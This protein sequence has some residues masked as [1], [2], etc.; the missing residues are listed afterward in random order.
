MNIREIIEKKSHSQALSPEEITWFVQSLNDDTLVDY[1]ITALLMAIFINGM[2]KEET[3]ALTKA[4]MA[5]GKCLNFNDPAVVDKHSTGGVGDKTS[6]VVAP[7]AAA[8]GVKVPMVAGKGLG[9]TGGTVDK[10]ESIPGFNAKVSLDDFAS[11]LKTN[12]LVLTGQT[13]EIA[14]ADKKLYAL[15]DVT[16]TINSIPL[17]TAS[18]MSKKLSEGVSGL[19][20][21][22]KYGSGAFRKTIAEARTLAHSLIETGQNHGVATMALIT[23]MNWPLGRMVGNA[24]EILE[25]IDVLRNQGPKDLTE[26]SLQLAAGMITLANKADSLTDARQK[27]QRALVSGAALV[28]FE[29]LIRSQGGDSGIFGS[30]STLSLAE[31]RYPVKA[32]QTGYLETFANDQIGLMALELGAGRKK[33]TDPIDYAVGLEFARKPGDLVNKGET[34]FTFHHRSSQAALVRS[35]EEDFFSPYCHPLPAHS[36]TAS[37]GGRN[38]VGYKFK[39]KESFCVRRTFHCC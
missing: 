32:R 21:D 39:N 16:S 12:G 3:S 19:V 30:P 6:F 13:E 20:M 4:M 14:P 18:I 17:M 26:L 31:K 11:L 27:A 29:E 7:L 36:T 35:L 28:K 10:A 15:R 5:S 24:L 33:K 37:L 1:Q 25:C 22:V 8:C 34:I 9:H 2:T 23:N 38:S